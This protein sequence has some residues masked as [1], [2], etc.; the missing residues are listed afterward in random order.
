M[1]DSPP[2]R[3]RF[4]R[5]ALL[6]AALLFVVL[7]GAF[8]YFRHYVITGGLR[9]RQKPGAVESY[10]MTELVR[11]SIPEEATGMKN[12]LN[13][14]P[15]SGDVEAGREL[16]VRN[17]VVCHAS[18]G[19]GKSEAG[20]GLFPP[21]LDLQHASI[22]QRKRTDGELFYFIKYGVRNTGMP[23]WQLPDQQLWQLV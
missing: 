6:I 21:P 19:S 15:D 8:I 16:Y 9:A 5:R 18:D 20:G 4:S 1:D 10:V 3:R 2:S 7:S 17:C 11:L 13:T 14:R 22:V 23:G 12:P